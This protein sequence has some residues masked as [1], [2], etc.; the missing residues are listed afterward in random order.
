[1]KKKKKKKV[2]LVTKVVYK[3]T[4]GRPINRALLAEYTQFQVCVHNVH[5]H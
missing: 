4:D 5:F 1:M 2:K 3:G